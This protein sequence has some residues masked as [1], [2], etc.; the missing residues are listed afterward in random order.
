MK[1]IVL[2]IFLFF[3]SVAC[4]PAAIPPRVA[5]EP[6]TRPLFWYT[7]VDEAARVALETLKK[8]DSSFAGAW[9]KPISSG[10][11]Q[12]QRFQLAAARV[13]ILF[14]QFEETTFMMVSDLDS[15]K[16][17]DLN[18]VA[19]RLEAILASSLDLNFPRA[20]HANPRAV[21]Q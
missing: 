9:S 17:P 1:N 16:R 15:D 14:V 5:P 7:D 12:L 18:W 13:E 10:M 21:R 4:S 11:R 2:V 3:S 8:S 6:D 19:T 20:S